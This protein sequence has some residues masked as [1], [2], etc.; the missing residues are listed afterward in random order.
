MKYKYVKIAAD[1]PI[2]TPITGLKTE[3]IAD[4]DTIS[5]IKGLL[6]GETAMVHA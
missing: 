5:K 4:A 1:P 6:T 3:G 2:T